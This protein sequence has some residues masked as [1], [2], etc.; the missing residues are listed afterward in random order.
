MDQTDVET[1]IKLL[2]AIK[3]LLIEIRNGQLRI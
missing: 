3:D 1:I 2:E